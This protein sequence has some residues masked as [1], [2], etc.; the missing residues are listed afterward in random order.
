MFHMHEHTRTHLPQLADGIK[1]DK[2]FQ[3]RPFCR[4]S[5]LLKQGATATSMSHNMQ[6]KKRQELEPWLHNI[7]R[8]SGM[9]ATATVLSKEHKWMPAASAVR[10]R[11]A[12]QLKNLLHPWPCEPSYNTLQNINNVAQR[13]TSFPKTA[14]QLDPAMCQGYCWHSPS[15]RHSPSW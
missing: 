1:A 12:I 3:V 10:F 5:Q 6:D 7:P 15:P 8:P 14:A 2:V 4:G 11:A 9:A 13:W